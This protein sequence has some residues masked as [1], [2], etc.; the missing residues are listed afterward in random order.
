[1]AK[2][3]PSSPRSLLTQ[4]KGKCHTYLWDQPGKRQGKGKYSS[5]KAER[6]GAQ[7]VAHRRAC[8]TLWISNT[9]N[10]PCSGSIGW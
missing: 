4:A 2:C 8:I 9:G 10:I 7:Q 6:K 1:M 5:T 3:L